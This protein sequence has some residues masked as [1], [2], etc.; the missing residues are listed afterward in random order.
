MYTI[1]KIEQEI[2]VAV[3]GALGK[4]HTPTVDELTAPPDSVWGDFAFPCFKIARSQGRNP[5]EIARE[6][7]PKIEPKGFIAKA[8]ARGP[9]V[10]FFVDAGRLAQELLREIEER[11]VRYGHSNVGEKKKVMVEYAQFNTHKAIHVGHVR[12]LVLGETTARILEANGYEVIRAT[13][14]GDIGIHVAKTL[15]GLLRLH[16]NEEPPK[17]KRGAWLGKIYAEAVTRIEADKEA[18]AEA[19]ALNQKLEKGERVIRKLWKETRAWSIA[20]FKEVFRELG[21]TPDAMYWESEME[22]PGRAVVKELVRKGIAKESQ[23]AIIVPLEKYGLDVMVVLKSDGTTLYSTRDFALALRKVK[24]WK[25]DRSL[26]IV[27]VRQSLYFKQLFKTL[28]L[29]GYKKPMVHIPYEF[30]TL[31]GR[32][33]SSRKGD[34]VTFEEMRSAVRAQAATETKKRHADWDEK[35]IAETAREIAMAAVQYGMLAHDTD[36]SIVFDIDTAASF[37]GATGPYL[38]YTGARIAGILRRD[39]K[40]ERSRD[41]DLKKIRSIEAVEKKLLLLL[42]R[43]P[44]VVLQAARD[45]RPLPLAAILFEIAKTFSEFYEN[46]PVLKAEASARAFRLDL[47]RA[48]RAVLEGGVRLLGFDLLKEM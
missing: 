12:N 23:G 16:K 42:A 29:Y 10:N 43:Y 39:R 2:L 26:I 21:V 36:R 11:G 48:A 14:H 27:D 25:P 13:Y 28:E 4:Q 1:Q 17:E 32:A 37:D 40:I 34:V 44:Q 18:E 8:E 7:A 9:F 45:Y 46:V 3:K 30:V 22:R 35:K 38:Q 41:R 5:V 33:I 24:E 19:N 15:W 20:E 31:K 47:I 6:L